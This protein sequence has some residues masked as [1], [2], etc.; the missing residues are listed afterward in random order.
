ME[1]K[2]HMLCHHAPTTKKYYG[3]YKF[4]TIIKIAL[5]WPFEGTAVPSALT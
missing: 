4:F 2:H 5:L 3:N 1:H